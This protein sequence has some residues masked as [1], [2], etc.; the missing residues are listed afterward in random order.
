MAG[1]AETENRTIVSLNKQIEIGLLYQE[2]PKVKNVEK[3]KE[4]QLKAR[5]D[6][7]RK[8]KS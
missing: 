4:T 2:K 6:V 1:L 3:G 7:S 8:R 5:Q